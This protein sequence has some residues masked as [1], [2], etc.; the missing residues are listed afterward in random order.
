[1]SWIYIWLGVTAFALI[2]E[3]CTNDMV[4]VWFAGGGVIAMILTAVGLSWYVHLPVFIVVSFVL[5]LS[6]R[7]MVLKYLYKG[8]EKTNADS[9][10]GKEYVLITAIEFNK[11]GTIKIND[12]VW[13]AVTENQ[14]DAIPK[15]SV[16]KVV[17][18]K[19][20]KYIVEKI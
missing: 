5:L 20:N 4:S 13:S 17:N 3:F 8:D 2:L 19:G 1:M 7:K 6:F 11:P 16:V 14:N 15:G 18:I 12:V 9:A 10:I